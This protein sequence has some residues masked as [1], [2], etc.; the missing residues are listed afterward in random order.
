MF[1]CRSR[2]AEFQMTSFLA[3]AELRK[4]KSQILCETAELQVTN[5]S[6]CE[7][8]TAEL[9]DIVYF[10][11]GSE[12]AELQVTE[13]SLCGGGTAGHKVKALVWKRNCETSSRAKFIV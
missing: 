3:E 7:S 1:S 6:V 5:C 10:L 13:N 12:T 2:S 4:F 11:C 8:R 9:R